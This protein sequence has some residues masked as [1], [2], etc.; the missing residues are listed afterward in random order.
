MNEATYDYVVIGAGSAGAALAARL[1]EGGQF[2]IALIEAGGP[3]K[4]VWFHVPLGVGKLLTNPAFVWP[5]RSTPQ[6]GLQGQQIYSP[7]GKVLG[8]SSAVNGMAYI[9]GDP[10]VFDGWDVDGWRW[11]DVLP[12]FRRL[13]NNPFSTSSD[14]GHTGPVKITD[15]KFYDPD[16]LSDAFV[17]ACVSGGIPE[18]VDYNVGSYEGA[19]YLEQTSWKG[20]RYSTARAYLKD[21][22]K[23]PNLDIVAEALVL[24]IDFDGRRAVGITIRRDGTERRIQARR[25]VLLAA[26]AIKSPQ[27]LEL[28]GIGAGERLRSLGVPIVNDLGAVGENLSDHLQVRRTYRATIPNTINDLLASPLH[29]ARFGLRYLLFKK[30]PLAG[31]SSTAH[32]ITRSKAGLARADVMIRMYQISGADRYSRTK[33]GGIDRFSGFTLGGF[34]LEPKSVGHVHAATPDPAADPELEPNYLD[35]P[36]DRETALNILKLASRLAAEP[37]LAKVIVEETRPGSNAPDDAALLDYAKESGQTAWHTVGSCRM[38]GANDSV[39]DGRLRVH[40][41]EGLRVVDASVLP[42]IPSSNTNAAAIMVGEKGAD[43]VRADSR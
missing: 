35:H 4:N 13:E 18:T 7:R 41:V 6:S 21:A 43:L 37:A 23:R 27:I 39:V 8:G 10:A 38:G 42:T 1:S 28:S 29:K 20:L 32:A 15:R 31:T 12:Y 3:N 40:G 5:F 19:R 30:G 14:R 22:K 2:R 36:D 33:A 24:R 16:P 11:E 34:M 26:G 9:W 17:A 25:E